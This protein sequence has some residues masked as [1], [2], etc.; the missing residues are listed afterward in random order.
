MVTYDS[1]ITGL[2]EGT[3]LSKVCFQLY[4]Y[5]DEGDVFVRDYTGAYVIVPYRSGY[6]PHQKFHFFFDLWYKCG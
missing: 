5:D 2:H 4:E 1:F 3:A 6:S